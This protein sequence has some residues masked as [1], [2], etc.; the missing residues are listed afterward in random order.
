[1]DVGQVGFHHQKEVCTHSVPVYNSTKSIDAH[2]KNHDKKNHN[3]YALQEYHYPPFVGYYFG[4]ACRN[5]M[6]MG[7]PF[8]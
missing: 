7:H 6:F 8:C 2:C 4:R 3:I 5:I 1:M